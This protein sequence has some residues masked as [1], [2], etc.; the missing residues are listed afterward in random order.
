M[1][2]MIFSG[3]VTSGQGNGKKYLQ[4]EWVKLQIQEKLGYNAYPGTLNIK[5]DADGVKQKLQLKKVQ[6]IK[7]CPA[8]GYCFGSVYKAILN[9]VKCAI[10]IPE[11]EG[12]PENLLE[13]ISPVY[14]RETLKLKDEDTVSI[15]T[16]F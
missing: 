13:V 10:I 11:V 8:Q 7:I 9:G 12:Y 1:T 5:L 4:L 3:T 2:T 15:T 16:S 14:L 6:P